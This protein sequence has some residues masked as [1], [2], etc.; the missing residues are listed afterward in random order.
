MCLRWLTFPDRMPGYGE[1][2]IQVEAASVNP[3]DEKKRFRRHARRVGAG[4]IIGV[5][6]SVPHPASAVATTTDAFIASAWDIA[7]AVRDALGGR[8][9]AV[10]GFMF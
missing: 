4:E 5:D 9:D 6:R 3:S 8:G 10:S 1:A 7:V 2:R